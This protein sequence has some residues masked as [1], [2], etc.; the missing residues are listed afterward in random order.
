VTLTS[1]TFS[2]T[3]TVEGTLQAQNLV[4]FSNGTFI[5]NGTA[6]DD[7]LSALSDWLTGLPNWLQGLVIALIVLGSIA[8]AIVA[9]CLISKGYKSYQ[10]A[11]L[12][13][14]Y[15]KLTTQEKKQQIAE[16]QKRLAIS[17]MTKFG[18]KM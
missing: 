12:E 7:S 9:L 13:A 15:E 8:A 6:S 1:G 2:V 10:S 5:A 11:K 16:T 3:A 4:G 18:E 14:Q 17:D